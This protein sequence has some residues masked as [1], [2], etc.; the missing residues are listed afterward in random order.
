MSLIGSPTTGARPP[1]LS[2]K[3]TIKRGSQFREDKYYF[4]DGNTVILVD[5]HLFRV[6]QSLFERDSGFFQ[7]LFSLPHGVNPQEGDFDPIEGKSDENPIVC[8]DTL[9]DFRALCWVLYSRPPDIIAQQNPNTVDIPK[10]ISVLAMSHKYD[11]PVFRSWSLDALQSLSVSSPTDFVRKCDGGKW[12]NVGRVLKLAQQCNRSTLVGCI[13][14]G[15][16]SHIS[17]S[18]R[19]SVTAFVQALG[20]AELSN[21]LRDFHGQAY[22]AYLK[23]TSIFDVRSVGT[24]A[25]LDMN[26]V[27]SSYVHQ[28]L[29]S[30]SE[31][32]K[33]RLYMGFWSLS[34]FRIRLAQ[35]PIFPDRPSCPNHARFCIPGWQDRWNTVIREAEQKGRC[36]NDPGKLLEEVH[37]SINGGGAVRSPGNRSQVVSCH[38]FIVEQFNSMKQNFDS[39]IADH[40]LIP[41]EDVGTHL[42]TQLAQRN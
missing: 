2:N 35:A 36:L 30:L 4:P 41:T 40:F 23:A 17:D 9:N 34:Q 13:Q 37:G 7:T 20:V 28:D 10:L 26:S 29:R 33:M 22:Y 42:F 21:D 39:R 5:G 8:Q 3:P 14:Q 24:I 25:A 11:F 12:D 18:S 19:E 16:L 31:S 15:W 38:G 6:H 32:R 27:P 1:K